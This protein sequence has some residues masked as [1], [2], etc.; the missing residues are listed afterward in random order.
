MNWFKKPSRKKAIIVF[1]TII[2]SVF[3]LAGST[4]VFINPTYFWPMA[5]AGLL[6]PIWLLINILFFIYWAINR[7]AIALLPLFCLIAASYHISNYIGIKNIFPATQKKQLAN[8][9]RVMTWNVRYFQPIEGDGRLNRR[10]ILNVIKDIQPDIICIQEYYDRTNGREN[11][12]D[13][14]NKILNT[15]HYYFKR[16][17]KFY[18]GMAIFSKYTIRD[19][20][21]IQLS[22]LKNS[23][24]CIFTDIAIHGKLLRIYSVHLRSSHLPEQFDNKYKIYEGF[25][26]KIKKYRSVFKQLKHAFVY[27]GRQVKIMKANM[28]TSPYPY[29]ITGD[30]NDTPTS[31]T[32]HQLSAGLKN[33]FSQ[34]GTGIGKTHWSAYPGV[35]IDYIMVSPAFNVLSYKAPPKQLSDHY[36]VYADIEWK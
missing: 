33:T 19:T 36:P 27:R 14:I 13:S 31:Y 23:N 20:G 4:A 11:L 26:G 16:L 18:R 32:Y 5:F 28:H 6:Y 10:A 22:P 29:I 7:K 25:T 24:Q 3:L 9:I 30:F 34:K 1:F 35:Q 21:F 17:R 15:N 12:T 8:R 2:T